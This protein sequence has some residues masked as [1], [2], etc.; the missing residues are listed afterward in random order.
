MSLLFALFVNFLFF[1]KNIESIQ[2]NVTTFIELSQAIKKVNAGDS[3][4]LADG[5]YVTEG[6]N[7]Q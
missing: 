2:Y 1:T 7:I 4:I 5:L 3:I 6:I